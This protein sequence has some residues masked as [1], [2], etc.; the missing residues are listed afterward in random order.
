M[1]KLDDALPDWKAIEELVNRLDRREP[2]RAALH[3]A[4]A[5]HAHRLAVQ[6]L[7]STLYALG[8]GNLYDYTEQAEAYADEA[9]D[10]L[11]KYRCVFAYQRPVA[12]PRRPFAAAAEI[13]SRLRRLIEERFR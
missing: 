2:L 12:P 3:Y 10:E 6:S 4:R 7:S 1:M 9:L 8:H 11:N 13:A 5:A